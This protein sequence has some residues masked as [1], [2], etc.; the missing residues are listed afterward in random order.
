MMILMVFALLKEVVHQTAESVHQTPVKP[1]V[2]SVKMDL[3]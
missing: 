1:Y 2:K 3:H